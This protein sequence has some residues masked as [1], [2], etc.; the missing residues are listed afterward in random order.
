MPD[1]SLPHPDAFYAQAAV[2]WLELGSVVEAR[3]ELELIS[4]RQREHPAV[5]EIWWPIFAEEENWTAALATAE[6]LIAQAPERQSGWIQR[7]YALHELKRTKEAYDRLF[8]VAKKFGDAYVIP[9]NLA[10]YQCQLGNKAEALEWLRR[11]AKAS[12]LETIRA[13]GLNDSDLAPVRDEL[14]KMR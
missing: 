12:D 6:K 11:A 9:Y 3:R 5:L 13:M 7:S 10:C 4:P 1:E 14:A 8:P 2:G